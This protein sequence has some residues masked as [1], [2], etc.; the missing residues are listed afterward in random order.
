MAKGMDIEMAPFDED[1]VRANIT[2]SEQD[3]GGG[4]LV[5]EVT[6]KNTKARPKPTTNL[7]QMRGRLPYVS[8]EP[9]LIRLRISAA[10]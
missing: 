1:H 7:D 2:W 6:V 9:L 5:V 4:K 10:R 3:V 8:H